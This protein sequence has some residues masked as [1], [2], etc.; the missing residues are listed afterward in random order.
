MGSVVRLIHV[1]LLTIWVILGFGRAWGALSAGSR[2]PSYWPK[3][4]GDRRVELLDG[5]WETW[6]LG[7]THNPPQSFD[8]MSPDFVPSRIRTRE[9][10][11]IP[12]C[13]DNELPG[14]LGYRGV[15]FFRR[16][17][18][19]NLTETG[20]RIQFQACSFYCRVWINGQVIGDHRAGGYVAFS[21]LAADDA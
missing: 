18:T 19:F 4:E 12:S 20:A 16:K 9:L 13:V 2:A 8:S 10:V 7:S 14:H 1:E 15:S 17:F 21:C 3:Y 11:G 6:R 5:V